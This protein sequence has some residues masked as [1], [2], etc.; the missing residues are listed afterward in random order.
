[1]FSPND[2]RIK[3]NLPKIKKVLLNKDISIYFVPSEKLKK[4]LISGNN[5][6]LQG[7]PKTFVTILLDD[8]GLVIQKQMLF[9]WL[10]GKLDQ[11]NSYI[12]SNGEVKIV[13]STIN[14]K[15]IL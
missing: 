4:E 11:K 8:K 2:S 13:D 6:L 9:K 10:E 14:V 3:E 1:M 7:I 12:L 5:P 15:N